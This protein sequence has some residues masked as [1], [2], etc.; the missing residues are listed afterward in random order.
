[1]D[2]RAAGV[3][4]GAGITGFLVVA[5]AVIELLNVEFS[6]LVGLPVGLLAGAAVAVGVVARY[7]S[8]VGPAR[9]AVDAAA[10]FGLAVAVLL[11]VSYVNLAGL[12]SELSTDVTVG[13][14]LLAAALTA[15]ASWRTA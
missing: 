7:D 2:S 6:A 4:V 12:R 3:A 13:V 9:H 8:L 14:A 5:V 11:A 1:M 10:G 15:V